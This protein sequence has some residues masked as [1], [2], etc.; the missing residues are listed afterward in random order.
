MKRDCDTLII[1][2]NYEDTN[3]GMLY[4]YQW[5]GSNNILIEEK[6]LMSR[7]SN[8]NVVELYDTSEMIAMKK[9]CCLNIDANTI[10]IIEQNYEQ[11]VEP[12]TDIEEQVLP[13]DIVTVEPEVGEPPA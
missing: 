11:P 10:V 6:Q 3:E 2:K 5:I 7:D 8:N 4:L 13:N 1:N 9:S 12:E